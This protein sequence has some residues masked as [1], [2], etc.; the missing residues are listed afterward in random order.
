[1][2]LEPQTALRFA[3]TL[4]GIGIVLQAVEVLA[5]R[6]GH[7][8]LCAGN[9]PVGFSMQWLTAKMIVRVAFGAVLIYGFGR[10][11]SV[12]EPVFYMALIF[13]SAGLILRFG[14]PL[15]GGS[16]SMMFQV[17]IGLLIASFGVANP[18]LTRVGLGWIAAQSVL[19]YFLAG[20]AK[21]RNTNWRTG[22]ALQT[23]LRS[24]G[25]YTLFSPA[26]SLGNSAAMCAAAS[27]AVILFEVAFPVVLFLPWEGKLAMLSAGLVFHIANA[28]ML[29][30]NRFIWAWA[31]TYPAVLYFN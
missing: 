14:G 24:D 6:A 4:L 27:W 26:R 12:I 20:V 17:L 18:I 29:G 13:S 28:A 9:R 25:P 2:T 19:S 23:L 8:R 21:L 7:A 15:G 16:D 31:A 3:Q 30:L 1:M 10:Y 11:L 22:V 5:T